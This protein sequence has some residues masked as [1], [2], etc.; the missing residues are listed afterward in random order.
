MS[1]FYRG[2]YVRTRF[3][4]HFHATSPLTRRYDIPPASLVI[5]GHSHAYS[6]GLLAN[7]VSEPFFEVAGSSFISRDVIRAA[8][9]EHKKHSDPSAPQPD[10]GVVYV[11]TGGAGGPL[12]MLPVEDWGFYERSIPGKHHFGHIMLDMSATLL[13]IDEWGDDWQDSRDKRSEFQKKHVRVYRLTGSQ[14]VCA[15]T[16][17]SWEAGH[18]QA[19]DRLVWTTV[20]VDG[21]ILD[22][23]IIEA[24]SCR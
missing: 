16:N 18:Y 3:A 6:R 8:K 4:P 21:K 22:R 5:S 14:L 20:G 12:D 19:A 23:F 17:E 2:Q 15:G 9:A 24:N 13:S 7:F 1:V 10:D 11:V